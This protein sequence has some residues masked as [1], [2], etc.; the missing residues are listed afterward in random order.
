MLLKEKNY[1]LIAY[2]LIISNLGFYFY[3]I[4]SHIKVI[5][6]VNHA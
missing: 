2:Y 4:L 6:C 5:S 1:L 3:F